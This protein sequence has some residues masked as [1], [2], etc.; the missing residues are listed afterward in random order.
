[1]RG[2]DAAVGLVRGAGR[3][4]PC[5]AICGACTS[6]S[7]NGRQCGGP[8][9]RGRRRLREGTGPDQLR[10]DFAG[11]ARVGRSS[12]SALG[13]VPQ[14]RSAVVWPALRGPGRKSG[15]G[16]TE[17]RS[18]RRRSGQGNDDRRRM[19]PKSIW[20][21]RTTRARMNTTTDARRGGDFQAA[22]FFVGQWSFFASAARAFEKGLKGSVR[23]AALLDGRNHEFAPA[24]APC[25]TVDCR[26]RATGEQDN[27]AALG[28][29]GASRP[30][31]ECHTH[32]RPTVLQPT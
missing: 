18:W 11:D 21:K 12:S 8:R 30:A 2:A 26:G 29:G 15:R 28:H 1:M 10:R 14:V 7:A 6:Y 9:C 17:R 22:S 24:G 20:S 16:P 3:E 13:E 19:I 31:A 5:R 25:A 23:A 4:A 32:W 27:L